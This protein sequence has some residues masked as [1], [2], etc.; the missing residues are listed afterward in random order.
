MND[1]KVATGKLA[2][3]IS[4]CRP[5]TLTISEACALYAATEVLTQKLRKHIDR[6]ESGDGYALEKIGQVSWHVSAALGFDI[7]NG[8]DASQHRSWAL[9][10]LQSLETR[11]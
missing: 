7:D 1:P 10:S 2:E 3:I 11:L 4:A 6:E 9:G 8:H 5:E